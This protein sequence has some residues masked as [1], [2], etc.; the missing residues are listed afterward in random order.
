MTALESLETMG[1]HAAK[2]IPTVER[3][4]DKYTRL[5]E[6]DLPYLNGDIRVQAIA[7]L[8]AIGKREDVVPIVNQMLR[9]VRTEEVRSR[10]RELLSQRGKP[11]HARTA[12]TS[13]ADT[14]EP[15]PNED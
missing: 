2:A 9:R 4:L 5:P 12:N 3:L 15:K 6:D 13:N 1:P 7:T 10:V 8:L 14:D 11:T